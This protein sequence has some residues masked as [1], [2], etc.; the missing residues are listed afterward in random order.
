MS[1]IAFY[2]VGKVHFFRRFLRFG[3]YLHKTYVRSNVMARILTL[4]GISGA[5]KTYIREHDLQLKD[6]PY[7][8]F[9]DVYAQ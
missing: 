9:A 1:I 8:N 6:L 7:V 3:V 4:S 2:S 5:G